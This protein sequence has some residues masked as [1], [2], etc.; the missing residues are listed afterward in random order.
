[1]PV[2][3]EQVTS[4]KKP[5]KQEKT[6]N[7]KEKQGKDQKLP[8]L[9]ALVERLVAAP[10]P[11]VREACLDALLALLIGSPEN[12]KVGFELRVLQV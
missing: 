6:R 4:N 10:A 5:E 1:L 9:Q 8:V 12:V 3:K 2:R 11:P 7:N